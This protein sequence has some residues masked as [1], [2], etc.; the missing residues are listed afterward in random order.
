MTENRHGDNTSIALAL[1]MMGVSIW[2]FLATL[3]IK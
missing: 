2:I 1:G 3:R